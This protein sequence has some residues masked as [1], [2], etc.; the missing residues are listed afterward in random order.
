MP[1]YR[2]IL[3]TETDP[4]APQ[5][6]ALWKA[7]ADNPLAMFE[8]DAAA[9]A[10]GQTLRD[11]AL[12]T[13]SAT[14]AGTTWVGLRTAALAAGAVGSYALLSNQSTANA[15][16]NAGATFAAAN[17]IYSSAGPAGS[18]GVSGTWRAMGRH[19]TNTIGNLPLDSDRR[20]T[21]FLRI[22]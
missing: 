4:E 6:S 11:A 7:V 1:T 16:H 3:A 22:S 10:A 21:L 17:L 9:V 5:V 19:D 12:N 14:A 20:T 8:G 18:G 2:T 13:G 15:N